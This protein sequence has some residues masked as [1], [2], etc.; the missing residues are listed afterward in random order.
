VG[1]IVQF[2]GQTPLNLARKLHDAGAP[3]IG[4]SVESLER[5][6]DRASFSR[7]STSSGSTSRKTAWRNRKRRPAKSRPP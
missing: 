1:V 2:G 4:T 7:W 5:A 6:G 3:I